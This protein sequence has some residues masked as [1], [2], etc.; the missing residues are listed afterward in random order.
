MHDGGHEESTVGAVRASLFVLPFVAAME[1]HVR[2]KGLA[3]V[4]ATADLCASVE[5][6]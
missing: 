6:R 1:V 2:E 3:L 5:S 4:F